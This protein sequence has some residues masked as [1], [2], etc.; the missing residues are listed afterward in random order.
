MNGTPVRVWLDVKIIL[1]F[2]II[3]IYNIT[4]AEDHY[5]AVT[6]LEMS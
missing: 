4:I 6:R 1:L 3:K 5:R 2:C